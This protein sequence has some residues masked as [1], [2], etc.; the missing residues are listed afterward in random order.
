VRVGS[1]HVQG[2]YTVP[3]GSGTQFADGSTA[4]WNLG[5]PVLKVY[6]TA[7]Y[8][9][10]YA[11]ENWSSTPTTLTQLAQTSEFTGALSRNWHTVVMTCFTFTNGITNWWRVNPTNTKFAAEYTELKALAAHLLSTYSG[12]GKTFILQNWEGDW[13]FM[14]S[15]TVTTH[16]PREYVDRYS[17]FLG[18][19]QKAVE[20]ARRETPHSGVQV[21]HAIELNR[22]VDALSHP[23]RRRIL[24]DISKRVR[25]DVV[26]YSA[27][28]AT[29]VDQG[30]WGVNQAAWEAATRPVFTRALRAIKAAFPDTPI[31]IGEF[32]YP[33]NEAPVTNDVPAM[34]QLTYDVA[35]EEECLTFLYWEVFDN[36]PSAPYTYRGYWL[37]K[38]D[39]TI[40][41][42]GLKMQEL[43]NG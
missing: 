1:A 35:L 14:D 27:Y 12:S 4:I 21:L 32:G 15:T 23:G 28:D 13:A 8:L 5:L 43:A 2:L 26:S 7:G 41:P 31:Q 10:D 11:L 40:S 20:D 6:C 19:R 42:S 24:R 36:E 39:G 3:N 25:P 18:V 37:V 30:S 16:V 38:P 22:V 29:I 34:I 33:E 17:A 9:T